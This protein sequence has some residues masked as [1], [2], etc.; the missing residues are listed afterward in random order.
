MSKTTANK[1]IVTLQTAAQHHRGE[2]LIQ[3]NPPAEDVT[4]ARV[5]IRQGITDSGQATV[6]FALKT[7]DG[8]ASHYQLGPDFKAVKGLHLVA[9]FTARQ[10]RSLLSV[11]DKAE[12]D[13]GAF[14]FIPARNVTRQA[15]PMYHVFTCK[16]CGYRLDMHRINREEVRP[17]A[18]DVSICFNCGHAAQLDATLEPTIPVTPEFLEQL[19]AAD[20]EAFDFLMRA[21]TEILRR[22]RLY[23][24][25]QIKRMYQG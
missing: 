19:N 8:I 11:V 17:N 4:E 15:G 22:G 20:P 3:G 1:M 21:R 13:P 18:G 7:P 10:L 24:P 6:C 2:P 12:A 25:E 16:A 9:E 23:S 5:I 14:P